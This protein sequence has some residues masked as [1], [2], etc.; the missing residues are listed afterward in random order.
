MRVPLTG[1]DRTF[2]HGKW[3]LSLSLLLF[4]Q[5]IGPAL[6]A[7][8]RKVEGSVTDTRG[9]PLEGIS[10]VVKGSRTGVT[11]DA[12]GHYSLTADLGSMLT[13][14]SASYLSRDE[15][16]DSR[17]TINVS[18][19]E[20][21]LS[22]ESVVVVGYG[23]Q[24]KVNLSGAVAQV[25]GK[26]LANK[27]V[28]NVTGALQGVL[29]GV[30][31]I[32]G[33]GQPGDEGY[34]IRIRG[35]SSANA[36][37]ALVLV[38]GI[39]QDLNLIDPSDVESISVLKDASASA[40]YGARAA[41]GVILVTTKQATL[42]KT[43]ITLNSNYGVNIT[44][45]QP[46][47]LDSWDEQTLIDEARLNATGTAE[48]NAE[49]YEWLKNPN[50]I[51]KPNPTQDRWEYYDNNN[52]VMEGLDKINHQQNHSISVGGGDQKLNYLLSGAYFKRDGV[53]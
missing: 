12:K 44:A 47:R 2:R 14:S 28:A 33:S 24:K 6:F 15:N 40:I 17:T 22:L 32:R 19:A 37:S 42:G 41:A 20:N 3:L 21:P 52:W 23:T 16:V 8:S 27:P 50:F 43:R 1:H 49:Q 13:F 9:V 39:E 36:A 7:Q 34:G 31:V 18:L 5:L 10:V 25:S 11:T 45:R 30:T 51:Y 38:D 29:P 48:F 53:M 4:I 46:K 26:D 35:F